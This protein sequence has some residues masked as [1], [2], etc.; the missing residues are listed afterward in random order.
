M[1]RVTLFVG[2]CS[3]VPQQKFQEE[4]DELPEGSIDLNADHI[5]SI[6]VGKRFFFLGG[7]SKE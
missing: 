2:F 5:Y 3:D 6:L 4:G 7:D 1:L